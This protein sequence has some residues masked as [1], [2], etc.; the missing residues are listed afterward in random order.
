MR[1]LVSH[2]DLDL[3][4]PGAALFGLLVGVASAVITEWIRAR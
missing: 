1:G 3:L 2:I 4:V